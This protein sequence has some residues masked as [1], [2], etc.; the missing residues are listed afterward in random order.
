MN[1]LPV[2]NL[3]QRNTTFNTSLSLN[4]FSYILKFIV[5]LSS[6]VLIIEGFN[7]LIKYCVSTEFFNIFLSISEL[8][9]L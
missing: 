8:S 6:V 5:K 9:I 3:S 2:V 4:A 1:S 7:I